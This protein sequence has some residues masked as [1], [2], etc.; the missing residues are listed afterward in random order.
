ML[1]KNQQEMDLI[2]YNQQNRKEKKLKERGKKQKQ[3]TNMLN[4][5]NKKLI[6]WNLRQIY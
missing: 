6:N 5:Y 3:K 1:M 4:T 2:L